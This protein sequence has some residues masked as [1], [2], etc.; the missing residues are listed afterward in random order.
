MNRSPNAKQGTLCGYSAARYRSSRFEHL[1][2]FFP[3][4]RIT[5]LNTFPSSEGVNTR[6]RTVSCDREDVF[7]QLVA[8]G[9]TVCVISVNDS[10][11]LFERID[12]LQDVCPGFSVPLER[13][14][15]GKVQSRKRKSPSSSPSSSGAPAMKRRKIAD[16][17]EDCTPTKLS[18]A[19]LHTSSESP[20]SQD[21]PLPQQKLSR[22]N[23]LKVS[24]A[25]Q[26]FDSSF[27]E[28]P[29]ANA[30]PFSTQG[31]HTEAANVGTKTQDYTI[32]HHSSTSPQKDS[33][34]WLR[35]ETSIDPDL[36]YQLSPSFFFDNPTS[37][38][39]DFFSEI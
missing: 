30:T 31:E 28:W 29:V 3:D 14:P 35:I 25:P 11:M 20:V 9:F 19:K 13:I 18:A 2:Y 33:L 17:I 23:P 16:R 34:S 39:E 6:K 8:K 4:S 38:A 36:V 10:H 7:A 26:A 27:F 1:I 24:I 22:F 21:V 12:S 32:Q 5:E 37:E 15:T